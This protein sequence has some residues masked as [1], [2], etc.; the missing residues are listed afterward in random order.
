[1]HNIRQARGDLKVLRDLRGLRG[2][3]EDLVGFRA[4][5]ASVDTQDAREIKAIMGALE[6]RVIA[7]VREKRVNAEIEAATVCKVHVDVV[8]AAH[9]VAAV[10]RDARAVMGT[11]A[12]KARR[13]HVVKRVA[14]VILGATETKVTEVA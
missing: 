14:K 12:T 13:D 3:P 5:T 9:R 11:T 4:R 7:G 10:I 2:L 6:T 8:R 1:M